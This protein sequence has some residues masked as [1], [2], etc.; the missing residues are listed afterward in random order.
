MKFGEKLRV[1]GLREWRYAYIA[2]GP[3]KR[4]LDVIM[5]AADEQTQEENQTEVA[6]HRVDQLKMMFQRHLDSEIV[7]VIDFY[8]VM[9]SS[10]QDMVD[11]LQ[12][13]HDDILSRIRAPDLPTR[14]KLGLIEVRQEKWRAAARTAMSLFEYITLNMQ[15]LRKIVKKM[16]KKVNPLLPSDFVDTENVF[17]IE[18]P[19]EPETKLV[20]AT[21]LT[22]EEIRRMEAMKEHKELKEVHQDIRTALGQLQSWMNWL[23]DTA[24]C[25]NSPLDQI[26]LANN[27]L[28][29]SLFEPGSLGS[30][31]EAP[32]AGRDNLPW[33]QVAS[34]VSEFEPVL[35]ELRLAT[36]KATNS[37]RLISVTRDWFES[38]AGIFEM[39]PSPDAAIA[40]SLGLFLNLVDT[41]LYMANYNLVIP[42][43][44]Q[45][46][47][48]LGVSHSVGGIIVGAADVTAMISA[49]NFSM[50]TNSSF[51]KPLIFSGAVLM[52]SNILYSLAYDFWGLPLL[53]AA[54]LVTGLGNARALN[55]R[56]IADYVTK[57]NRTRASAA[58]VGASCLGM[59]TGPFLSLPLSF[60]PHLKFLGLTI[61]NVTVAGWLMAAVWGLFLLIA[62][63]FFSEPKAK[64]EALPQHQRN[65]GK[66]RVYDSPVLSTARAPLLHAVE[67]NG[68]MEDRDGRHDS[69]MGAVDG[70]RSKKFNMWVDPH[71]MP[72]IATILLLF[73]LKVLQQGAVSSFPI[74]GDHYQWTDKQI[75]MFLAAMG[76][77]VL[78]VN[79]FVGALSYRIL[80]R[81]LCS[82]SLS[83][84]L[85]GSVLV[86][87]TH[88]YHFI[89]TW[90]YFTGFSVIYVATIVLEG[91]AMSLMSKVIHPSWARGTFNAGL[92]ATEAGSLGRLFG[93]AFV[94]IIGGAVGVSTVAEVVIFGDVNYGVFGILTLCVMA[95]TMMVYG[96]LAV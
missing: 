94:T 71:W 21:F 8:T 69:L 89:A 73:L 24:G 46:C 25:S 11:R 47:E 16:V 19:T 29:E 77:F 12:E 60:I 64:A 86:Y 58:F 68:K 95:F 27:E 17:E 76:I 10:V 85:L 28:Y 9:L 5:D 67:E 54:R 30:T 35:R 63:P 87:S 22:D 44:N 65:G 61:D 41:F 1:E 14:S 52:V 4:Q 62:V 83:L 92:L 6:R 88:T 53:V 15:A 34:N 48:Q 38:Q 43:N 18:H 78:P 31:I 72:T 57:E 50:W 51:R 42:L 79:F 81:E 7:K 90:R 56:Y 37:A 75:G 96:K 33:N 3:L 36:I 93:N 39:P 59:A 32:R 82:I 23:N 2:Y 26:T 74:Y 80:D 70:R 45:F 49:V 66:D 55:R 84:C 13:E 20:Q 40:T 91:A